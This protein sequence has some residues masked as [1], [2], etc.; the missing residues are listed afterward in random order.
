MSA[1][2]KVVVPTEAV[3]TSVEEIPELR[4]VP[5][6]VLADEVVQFVREHPG[7]DYLDIADGLRVDLLQAVRVADALADQGILQDCE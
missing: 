4:D 5:D 2:A 6:D 3:A 7:A 1:R